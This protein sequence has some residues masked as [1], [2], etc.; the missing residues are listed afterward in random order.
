[1]VQGEAMEKLLC[2]KT[3]TTFPGMALLLFGFLAG[4]IIPNLVYRFTWKQQAFSAVY[5][6]GTYGRTAAYGKEYLYQIIGMRGGMFLLTLLCGFT[7]F[8]VPLAVLS[9]IF[10]G[11]GLGMVF[12]MSILQFGLAGGAVA[13]GLFASPV[14]HLYSRVDE[15]LRDGLQRIQGNLAQSWDFSGKSK[16][17]FFEFPSVDSHIRAWN[18]SGM[19][20]KSLDFAANPWIYKFFL[21]KI[22]EKTTR[23]SAG[24]HKINIIL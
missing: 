20:H 15:S 19:V 2:I 11:L 23:Y 4:M 21:D 9:M 14:S 5:L 16:Q 24:Y 1:M 13:A 18:P 8:G 17:L 7:V 10:T 3:K 6:L 12:V 22:R